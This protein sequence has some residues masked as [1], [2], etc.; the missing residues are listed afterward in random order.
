MENT[1]KAE[2]TAGNHLGKA[3]CWL[4]LFMDDLGLAFDGPIPVAEDNAATRIIAHTGK[5]THNV[6]LIAFKTISLQTLVRERISLCSELLALP[7]I[8]LIISLKL[9]HFLLFLSTI[10]FTLSHG[11][12]C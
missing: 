7:I 3:L 5:L 6:N 10:G 4:H 2:M 8:E 12:S 11:S 9:Y 1:T